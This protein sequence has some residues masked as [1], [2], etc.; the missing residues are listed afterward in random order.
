MVA[1]LRAHIQRGCYAARI[2]TSND[3]NETCVIPRRSQI[4][5]SM[6]L[7]QRNLLIYSESNRTPRV[8]GF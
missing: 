8:T 7:G 1:T 6:R 4:K 2:A 3:P 5:S